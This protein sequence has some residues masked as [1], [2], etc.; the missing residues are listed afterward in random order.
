MAHHSKYTGE[1]IPNRREASGIQERMEERNR[2][3]QHSMKDVSFE[4]NGIEY[5]L[6]IDFYYIVDGY[7]IIIEN[8]EP[9]YLKDLNDSS[10]KI[11]KDWIYQSIGTDEDDY[12]NRND[13][14][15]IINHKW[16]PD[17]LPF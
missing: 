5:N 3:E 17:S 14:T 1:R 9:C 4:Y 16:D 6:D 10:K 7:Y 11:I 13:Y 2:I 15:L 8:I 12:L